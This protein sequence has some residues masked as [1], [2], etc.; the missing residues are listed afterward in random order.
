MTKFTL[1]LLLAAGS[2]PVLV[3]AQNENID[4]A[5]MRRI[6]EE[7]LM[8]TQIPQIAH[9]LTDV[10][11]PR[12]TNS[13]GWHRAADWIVQ[14]LQG[15]G[16]S[17]TSIEAWGE[18]GMGWSAEK[19]RS[20]YAHALLQPADCLCDPLEREYQRA[21]I[22]AGI[23]GRT[24]GFRLDCGSSGPDEREGPADHVLRHDSAPAFYPGCRTLYRQRAGRPWGHLYD[25]KGRSER[26]HPSFYKNDGGAAPDT[27]QRGL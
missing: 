6:R 1:L 4:T 5:M 8:H 11:G 27:V 19:D 3:R 2:L 12:L 14:T 13:P 10:C 20:G 22:G 15:W 26:H 9:Q 16:L 7:E 17:K 21:G 23:P 24:N 25:D 18:F